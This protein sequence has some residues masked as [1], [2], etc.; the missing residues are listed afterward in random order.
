MTRQPLGHNPMG[1]QLSARV[2]LSASVVILTTPLLRR[3]HSLASAAVAP[4]G[5]SACLASRSW[6]CGRPVQPV[7]RSESPVPLPLPIR[8]YI[9]HAMLTY[10]S[11]M[12]HGVGVDMLCL[13]MYIDSSESTQMSKQELYWSKDPIEN[14]AAGALQN[15]IDSADYYADTYGVDTASLLVCLRSK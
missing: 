7:A 1:S 14:A 8:S 4:V 3:I 11:R 10:Y 9:I 15:A 6:L 5:S 12:Y 2:S 13:R